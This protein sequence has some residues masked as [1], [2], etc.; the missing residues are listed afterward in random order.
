MSDQEKDPMNEKAARGFLGRRGA[1]RQKNVFEVKNHKFIPRYFKSPTFCS[2]CKDFIWWVPLI[3]YVCMT[4]TLP[5]SSF[6]DHWYNRGVVKTMH[7]VVSGCRFNHCCCWP[8]PYMALL[9][10]TSTFKVPSLFPLTQLP[11]SMSEFFRFLSQRWCKWD[12][13]HTVT[14]HIYGTIC[15]PFCFHVVGECSGSKAT[16]AKVSYNH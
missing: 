16:N 11:M 14:H 8:R 15:E 13:G 1:V 3:I 6:F 7:Q 5:C 10:A 9:L 2:H 12:D 4:I